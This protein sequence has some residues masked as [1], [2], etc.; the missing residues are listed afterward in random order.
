MMNL[1][2]KDCLHIQMFGDFK[3][4]YKDRV[5]S[6]ENV[7]AKQVW[8]LLEYI[9]V[10][11]G[12]EHSTERMI[13]A[14]WEENDTSDPANA[15]KNLAYRLREVLKSNLGITASDYI[16]FRHGAYC[17]NP[18]MP[19][20]FDV[21]CFETYIKEATKQ[22]ASEEEICH[23]YK[24]AIQLYKGSYMP[25]ASYKSWVQ[26]QTVYYQ[27]IYMDTADKLCELL[28]K[29][30]MF[31]D[32]EEISRAAITCDPF[33]ENNHVHL[34]RALIGTNN[35]RKALA[36]YNNVCKL[37]LDELGVKP[38]E[39]I[40]RL[41]TEVINRNL[42]FER[43]LSVIKEELKESFNVNGALE[44]NYEVFKTIYRL[45]ARAALR[46]GKSIFVALLTVTG[47]D[48]GK[49]DPQT[50]DKDVSALT[51]TIS[52]YLRRDDVICRY[53]RTQFLVMLSNI[54]YENTGMVLNRLI[55]Q[56]NS[57]KMSRAVEVY[58]QV[59]ALDPVELEGEPND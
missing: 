43:D 28:E 55:K 59:R 37:Y 52:S 1:E 39:T 45:Q 54:T 38:S 22:N 34:I 16:I 48:R 18:E 26:S 11:R 17:W 15:L 6:G 2:E 29:K 19:C 4:S 27:R 35:Q 36:H 42:E 9:L 8:S 44:C 32:V 25:Q 40:T 24:K 23:N 14:L 5:L 47:K 58:G 46:M 10:N 31:D 7:R 53:G 50:L 49:L 21:D 56:I 30:E 12:K 41:Y 3:L 20:V 33:V 13:E 57:C 51:Q